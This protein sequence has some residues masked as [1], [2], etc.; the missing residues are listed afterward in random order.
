MDTG[1][2]TNISINNSVSDRNTGIFYSHIEFEVID[3]LC[4][5]SASA[6]KLEAVVNDKSLCKDIAKLSGQHQT[7]RLEAFHSLIIQF[8]PKMYIFSFIGMLCRYVS[9]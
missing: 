3:R 6:V 2:Q 8:A 5:G 1:L 7:C 4:S 9:T